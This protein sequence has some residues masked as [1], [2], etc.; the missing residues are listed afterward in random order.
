MA[1]AQSSLGGGSTPNEGNKPHGAAYASTDGESF[2]LS[3]T[4]M[5]MNI[6]KVKVSSLFTTD[7]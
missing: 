3:G 7:D 1:Q 6:M 4:E 2:K 5:A